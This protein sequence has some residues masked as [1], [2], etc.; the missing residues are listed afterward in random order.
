MAEHVWR[1]GRVVGDPNDRMELAEFWGGRIGRGGAVVRHETVSMR[2][3][4]GIKHQP[5]GRR[6]GGFEVRRETRGGMRV[7]A[8][9]WP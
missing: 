2:M 3:M 7:C 4:T 8:S 1:S 9:S 5:N 6:P